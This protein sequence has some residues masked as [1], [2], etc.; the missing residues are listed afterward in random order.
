M[1]D[2]GDISA[3]LDPLEHCAAD[4]CFRREAITR[5]TKQLPSGQNASAGDHLAFS[6]FA[7]SFTPGSSPSVNSIPNRSRASRMRAAWYT[8]TGARPRR[9]RPAALARWASPGRRPAEQLVGLPDLSAGDHFQRPVRV[10][11]V[12]QSSSPAG[13]S[14]PSGLLSASPSS[15]DAGSGAREPPAPRPWPSA[16]APFSPAT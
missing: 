4:T 10:G 11:L 5:P 1:L 7:F 14:R 3:L 15:R 12:R 16:E 8:V 2:R 9:S 6:A 13:V